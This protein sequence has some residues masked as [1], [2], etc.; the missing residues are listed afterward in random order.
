MQTALPL[1]AFVELSTRLPANNFAML[2]IIDS[3]TLSIERFQYSINKFC[4]NKSKRK[5]K[6]T[7]WRLLKRRDLLR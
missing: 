4:N 2:N 1:A 6:T 7:R 5:P 3:F